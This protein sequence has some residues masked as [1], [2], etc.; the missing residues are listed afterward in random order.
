VFGPR[1]TG[2][3]SI[4]A[5]DQTTLLTDKS[6]ILARWAEHFNALLNRDLSICD[7]TITALPQLPE[8]NSL[9]DPAANEETVKAL[10]QTSGKGPGAGGIQADIYKRG[11][12]VLVRT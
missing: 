1:A 11:G 9:V 7:E 12:E 6:D 3:T 10:K 5:S 2:A 4:R 8:N